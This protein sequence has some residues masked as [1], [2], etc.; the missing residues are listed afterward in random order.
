M[1]HTHPSVIVRR[2]RPDTFGTERSRPHG[3]RSRL[4]RRRR[5][6]PG[7]GRTLVWR[8]QLPRQS[9]WLD[10]CT[11]LPLTSS[12]LPTRR[13]VN[14]QV[15]DQSV[16]SFANDYQY[17][18]TLL[19]Y[20]RRAD[21]QVVRVE[22]S[23]QNRWLVHVVLPKRL[24][25]MFDIDLEMMWMA[26]DYDRV[27]P[28][29]LEDLQLSLRTARVDDEIA[30]LVSAD[31]AA[32]RMTRRRPGGTAVL[33]INAATL[34]K[35]PDLGN[36][37]A[38]MLVT[39]D[40]FNVTVPILDPTAFFGRESDIEEARKCLRAGQHLGIFGLRKA[41]KSSLLNQIQRLVGE[42]RW[43]LARL[44]LNGYSGRAPR[45]IE[46][47]LRRLHGSLH[48]L[49]FRPGA[50]RSTGKTVRI[51]RRYWLDDLT[52]LLDTAGDRTGVLIVIDEIDI[53]L[54][55]RIVAAG[56]DDTDRSLLIGAFTQL[57]SVAQQRQAEGKAYPVV[58]SAG[59]DPH[60]FEAPSTNGGD[61]PLYQFS[62]IVFLDPLDRE[63]L[64]QMVRTLGKR[65][66]MRFRDHRLID[67]LRE[68]YGGHPL[69][70][71]QACSWLHHNRPPNEIP[72]NVT[73]E[74][75]QR[76]F[77]AGGT[78]TPLRHAQDTL[79]EFE[80]WYPEE[81]MR[82]RRIVAG[83][84]VDASEI[85]HAVDY[86]LVDADGRLRIRALTHSGL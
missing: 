42:E 20:L 37:L 10:S 31:P 81:A 83:E 80:D 28:R 50:L 70:T 56:G 57:R 34:D 43:A 39:V 64:S 23:R 41:G 7:A 48:G 26:T 27:E 79:D 55:G 73:V 5:S 77:D 6:A 58:L 60:I 1:Q 29:V 24:G 63:A 33:P 72:Y 14:Q 84:T 74:D 8:D 30:V 32:E 67:E 65:T 86:G 47:L 38:K 61:N 19:A 46:D 66:G 45:A 16:Q 17:G 59:V 49:G 71:R 54:P 15:L 36:A 9:E 3:P 44:D 82:V 12:N 13:T 11:Q 2:R 4:V 25:E 35:A 76:A 51:L 69:L 21:A 52:M 85:R 68:E 22:R 40:H 53:V 78:G 75:L 18:H 62:R